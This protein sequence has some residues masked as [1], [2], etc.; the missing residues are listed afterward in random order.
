[1]KK[2]IK[3]VTNASRQE[4]KREKDY[5]KVYICSSPE[6]GKANKELMKILS[7][8][9]NV[10]KSSLSIIKGEKSK[11]KIIEIKEPIV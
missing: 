10:K 9:L 5:L 4:V 2:K 6:K 1:M 7:N 3:V 11:N 8:Y